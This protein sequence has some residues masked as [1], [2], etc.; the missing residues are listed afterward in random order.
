MLIEKRKKSIKQARLIDSLPRCFLWR[1]QEQHNCSPSFSLSF[2]PPSP[3]LCL[4][5][6]LP[7]HPSS[8]CRRLLNVSPNSPSISDFSDHCS[9][10]STTSRATSHFLSWFFPHFPMV[11]RDAF[12]AGHLRLPTDTPLILLF[13]NLQRERRSCSSHV[14]FK[15]LHQ[16]IYYFHAFSFLSTPVKWL[17]CAICFHYTLKYITLASWTKQSTGRR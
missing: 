12:I 1:C 14:T 3:P 5:H 6:H 16:S 11:G 10:P 4:I 17:L 8:H 13:C 15:L 9:F 2:S 7:P